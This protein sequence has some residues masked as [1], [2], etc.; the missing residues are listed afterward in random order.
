MEGGAGLRLSV[1]VGIVGD[2]GGGLGTVGVLV[3]GVGVGIGVLVV[4]VVGLVVGVLVLRHVG[5]V[6]FAFSGAATSLGR[7]SIVMPCP[8]I[9][10]R[11]IDV[12]YPLTSQP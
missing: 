4:R 9:V 6:L 12:I 7:Q 10:Y 11:W 2:T 8:A 3:L 1:G 5:R